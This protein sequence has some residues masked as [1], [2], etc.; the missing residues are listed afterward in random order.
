[1]F[2]SNDFN[3]FI[4]NADGLYSLPDLCL[5][6]NS[7]VNDGKSSVGEVARLV[8]IDP[9]LTARVL[10]LA[11]SAI[12]FKRRDITT[13]AEAVA[14]IGTDELNNIA[15]ATSAAQ[16]FRDAG[17][18]KIDLHDYWYHSVVTAV[19][20]K[21]IYYLSSGKIDGSLFVAGLLHNIGLLVVLERLPY[22]KVDLLEVIGA[23]HLPWQYEK[24]EL[25]FSFVEVSSALI[26]RWNISEKL[27]TIIKNQY[28]PSEAV[29]YE[30][31][32]LVLNSAI[33]VAD[34]ILKQK[35]PVSSED[36][37]DLAVSEQLALDYRQLDDII[38]N[39]RAAAPV[40]AKIFNS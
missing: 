35:T 6:L 31:E 20:A 7:L 29:E 21:D 3:D 38:S 15:I 5:Q 23:S 12:Y 18:G 9:A 34:F 4:E 36:C 27:A 39:V 32:T 11:N 28:T 40:V 19:L 14:N 16:I 22:Y 10:K 24:K 26:S 13:I 30:M 8:S 2:D 33:I 17:G 37:I 25:G 1:M